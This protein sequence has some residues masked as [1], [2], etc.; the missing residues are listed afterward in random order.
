MARTS[1]TPRI[2]TLEDPLVRAA[3]GAV[4]AAGRVCRAVQQRRADV[5]ALTKDDRSPVTIADFASQA[6]VC[7]RLSDRTATTAI[8]AEE[9]AAFLR[10][11]GRDA[12]LEAVLEAVRPEWSDVTASALLEALDLGGADPCPKG[13]WTLDPIDGTKDPCAAAPC[14]LARVCRERTP[15]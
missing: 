7:R 13:F 10:Q 3:I 2:E 4:R 8:V 6:I 14:H 11:P 1:S 9:D 15:P 12:Y 5:G